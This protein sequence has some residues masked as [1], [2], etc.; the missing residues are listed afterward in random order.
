MILV[1]SISNNLDS[2]SN[3]IQLLEAK[4]A[5]LSELVGTS[6]D[7]V[8]NQLAA[9]NILMAVVGGVITLAGIVLSIYVNNKKRDVEK[10]AKIVDETKVEVERME[11]HTEQL[12][13][14]MNCNLDVLYKNL[15]KEETNA[16][17][18][19]LVLEP[20]DISNLLQLL[21]A[22]DLDE[23]GFAKLREAYL[24]LLQN[25][26]EHNNK[27]A[28][29]VGFVYLE[30]PDE[31]DNYLLVFFQH[32]C[33][34]ALK[35]DVIRPKLIKN[36]KATC[37]LAFK[38]DIIKST[39]DL[40]KV[41][42]DPNATFNKE[43]VLVAFLTA[44]NDSAHKNLSELANILEQNISSTTLLPAAIERCTNNQ[45][46]L[47]LFGVSAPADTAEVREPVDCVYEKK[48]E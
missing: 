10:L 12:N 32:Y 46:Y 41:L 8:A 3:Q 37:D 22:R 16:L 11:E 23:S 21:L 9:S 43:D 5:V 18:D 30:V 19:R 45:V 33:D 14:Q 31:E 39:I 34:H 13:M 27:D 24:K 6:N 7:C 1:E 17:L 29:E 20:R 4:V 28:D 35:D 44:L 15:R 38:R 47:S 42:S 48:E 2:L 36:F 40:C 25:P 26:E